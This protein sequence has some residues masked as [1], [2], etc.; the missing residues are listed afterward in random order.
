MGMELLDKNELS[1]AGE[2]AVASELCRRKMYAQVTLGNLK[3]TDILVLNP[4]TQKM[5]TIE[6]KSKQIKVWGNIKGIK[7]KNTFFVF[8][9]YFQKGNER[10]D[11]YILAQDDWIDYCKKWSG[12][13]CTITK[14]NCPTWRNKDGT[15]WKGAEIKVDR[16]VDCK[17]KWDK[18]G[19]MLN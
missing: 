17:E 11:F 16:I 14:D 6:V 18:I 1:L 5:V 15:V 3:K 7:G 4:N 13:G 19:K 2:Y 10:P 12:S 8:V 9:D